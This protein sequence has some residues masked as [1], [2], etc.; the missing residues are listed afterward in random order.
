MSDELELLNER[1]E[2]CKAEK[3]YKTESARMKSQLELERGKVFVL[4]AWLTC[5]VLLNIGLAVTLAFAL[6]M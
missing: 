4:S 5:S 6:V 3:L 1:A 2:H